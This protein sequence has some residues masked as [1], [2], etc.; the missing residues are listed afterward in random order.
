ML[1]K[2]EGFPVCLYLD[3]KTNSFIEE[4][5]TSNFIA[6]DKKGSYLTPKSS[7]ILGSITN[8]S[9]MQLAYSEGIDVQHRQVHVD[10]LSTFSE[11][12]AC[13]TAVV[14]TPI[15]S[16]FHNNKV[17]FFNKYLYTKY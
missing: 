2:K 1:A 4:F 3:A 14:V 17:N 13:G 5:S 11:V 8:K 15:E 6:I 9:L 10:E 7:A 16:I 12:A